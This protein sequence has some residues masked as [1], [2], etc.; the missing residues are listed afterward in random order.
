[1]VHRIT[2]TAGK[3]ACSTLVPLHT[4]THTH[5][6]YGQTVFETDEFGPKITSTTAKAP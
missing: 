4:Y 6:V 2:A 3:P 1:M 5:R